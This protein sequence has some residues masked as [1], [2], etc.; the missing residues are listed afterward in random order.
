MSKR[1][2]YRTEHKNMLKTV[3]KSVEM[4]IKDDFMWCLLSFYQEYS[5][6]MILKKRRI[7]VFT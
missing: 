5:I 7:S 4:W 6:Q 2:T 1:V 3:E